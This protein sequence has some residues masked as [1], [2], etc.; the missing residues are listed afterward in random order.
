[1]GITGYM[2]YSRPES[3]GCEIVA[4]IDVAYSYEF[5]MFVVV[6]TIEPLPG[7]RKGSYFWAADAGCSC[8]MPFDGA[9]WTKATKA[10]VIRAFD[11]WCASNF[12][13]GASADMAEMKFK[14]RSI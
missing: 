6:R 13:R 12:S 2:P 7:I 3:V 9:E 1:M 5:D 8:P 11:S 10:E 4:S 14:L